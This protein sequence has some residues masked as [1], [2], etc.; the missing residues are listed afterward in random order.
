VNNVVYTLYT[1][2]STAANPCANSE[3]N[4]LTNMADS[5]PIFPKD[6]LTKLGLSGTI[7]FQEAL[8]F[9]IELLSNAYAITSSYGNGTMGH[10]TL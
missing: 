7:T 8:N 1:L 6:D 4:C 3:A 10:A 5:K 9:D 2:L